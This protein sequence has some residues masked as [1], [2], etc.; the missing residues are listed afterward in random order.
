MP[1]SRSCRCFGLFPL[2]GEADGLCQPIHAQDVA[3]AWMAALQA[4]GA[5]NRAYNLSG[6]EALPY[7]DMVARVFAALGRPRL[8]LPVPLPAFRAAVALLRRLP[9]YR[10]WSAAMV[11]RMNRD[12]LFDHAEAA[13]DLAFKP[14]AFALSAE[15]VAT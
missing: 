5:A 9:R 2:F 10:H 15:D 6:G 13:R 8:L 4:P 3:G 7:R 11:E 14:K 12:L 1:S